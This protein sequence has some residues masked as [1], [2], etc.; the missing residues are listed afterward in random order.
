M[1]DIRKGLE[2]FVRQ[3][4][5]RNRSVGLEKFVLKSAALGGKGAPVDDFPIPP[6]VNNDT[7][8]MFIEEICQRAQSD[9]DGL[10]S[11]LQRYIL[12][13]LEPGEREG[14]RYPF[15]LRGEGGGDDEV[16][17]GEELL[18]ND[19]GLALQAM[20]HNEALMRMFVMSQGALVNSLAK[21]LES[22][23]RMMDSMV[24]QKYKDIEVLEAAKSQQHERDMQLMLASGAEDRKG[25]A[26][27]KLDLLFPLVINKLAGKP[28]LPVGPEGDIFKTLADSLTPEQLQALAPLLS[29]EQQLLLMTLLRAAR[30]PPNGSPS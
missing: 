3:Q 22:T 11:K 15:R 28:V 30:T 7:I 4:V 10:G 8:G 1:A 27:K 6:D 12:V 9:A 13:A 18:P 17:D 24:S 26:F 29:Q 19:K 25:E 23:E 16:E 5:F 14:P 21:R 20:R 2:R